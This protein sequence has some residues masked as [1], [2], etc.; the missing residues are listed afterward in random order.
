MSFENL[1]KDLENGLGM[2]RVNAAAELGKLKDKGAEKILIEALGDEIMAVRNNAAYSLG[3]LGSHDAV[4]R[5]IKALGMIGSREAISPIIQLL[6][7][8]RSPIVK[9]SAIRSLG[10]IGGTKALQAIEPFTSSPDVILAAVAKQAIE[11]NNNR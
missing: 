4:P 11:K 1:I 6:A 8:D 2:V 9:K 10:Q 5:L 3:E 7:V